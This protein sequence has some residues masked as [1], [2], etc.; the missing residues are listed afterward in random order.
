MILDFSYKELDYIS[1]NN[2][3]NINQS[4][5]WS[6]KGHTLGEGM[7]SPDSK[8]FYLNIPKN[9]SSSIKKNLTDLNW[10]Y[11]N[12][13]DAPNAKVIVALR[14]PIERWVS[15]ITEYLFMYHTNV[16]DNIADPFTY[17]FLP[18]IGDKLGVD[19]LF[20]QITFDDHTER[21][22]VFLHNIDFSRCEWL[23]VDKEFSKNFSIY[24]NTI[25]YTNSF[26]TMNKENN[27]EDLDRKRK[28]KE[29]IK[30]LIDKDEFKQYNLQQWFWCDYEL[31]N[32]VEFYGR[33][34]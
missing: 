8:Y 15:G 7:I 5:V 1:I 23:K 4:K 22:A 2:Q 27:A 13:S 24:L 25:G 9:S 32:Q 19:L 34:D 20:K 18:L 31:I 16:I 14:D 30:L 10:T 3:V 6:N 21:Q 12:I 29:V 17:D 28:L 11:G 26:A 33:R